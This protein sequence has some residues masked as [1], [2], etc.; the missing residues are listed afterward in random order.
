MRAACT[1]GAA[2][3]RHA[4][5]TVAMQ[6]DD[7]DLA[8]LEQVRVPVDERRLATVGAVVR[9]P[10]AAAGAFAFL[11]CA[12]AGRLGRRSRGA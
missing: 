5:R 2:C 4:M 7:A 12:G 10:F 3:Y 11:S 9:R 8:S 6:L 1:A